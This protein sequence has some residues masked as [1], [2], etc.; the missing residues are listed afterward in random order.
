MERSARTA[1]AVET[2]HLET[3]LGQLRKAIV[4]EGDLGIRDR[5]T[6]AAAEIADVNRITAQRSADLAEAEVRATP[7][8]QEK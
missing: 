2:V 5:L 4:I 7:N 6:L 8:E 1:L 3:A